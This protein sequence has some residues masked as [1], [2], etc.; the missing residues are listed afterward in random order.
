MIQRKKWI[1]RCCVALNGL[2]NLSE[3]QF[4]HCKMET[5]R[6]PA[7]K[8]CRNVTNPFTS[9]NESLYTVLFNLS[10]WPALDNKIWQKWQGASSKPEPWEALPAL[11]VSQNSAAHHREQAQL[12]CSGVRE[13]MEQEQESP[14]SLSETSQ[15][16]IKQHL[17]TYTQEPAQSRPS[18]EPS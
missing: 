8:D 11:P 1:A 17:T 15:P 10:S 18:T 6:T 7:L 3:P 9:D 13:N 14:W 4:P 16:H 5:V 2:Y 12:V